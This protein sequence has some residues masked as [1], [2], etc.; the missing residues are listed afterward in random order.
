MQEDLAKKGRHEVWMKRGEAGV[1]RVTNAMVDK[2]IEM[3]CV[4]TG[5]VFEDFVVVTVT[6]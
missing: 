3:K 6:K 2:A 1:C 4:L 5:K